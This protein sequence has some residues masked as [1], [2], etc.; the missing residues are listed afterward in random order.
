MKSILVKHQ[1]KGWGEK[2]YQEHGETLRIRPV[3]RYDDECGNGHNS[4]SIT[5]SI[6]R[7]NG[8]GNWVE[9]AG[10][11]CHEDIA[12]HFPE[13]AP[14]IKWHLCA[15]DGPMHYFANTM[16]LAGDK[17]CY[18][19]K[20]GEVHH[21]RNGRTGKICWVLEDQTALE[22]YVDSYTKP[23]GVRVLEYVP[24]TRI[25]EGKVPEL[26]AARRTAIWPEATLEQLQ[27]KEELEKHLAKIIPEFK[28]AVES[29]G[30]IY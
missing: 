22:K 15:S 10:G 13:L 6:D 1:K 4:F 8:R 19:L 23:E 5:A 30:F 18:G 17:D 11:C 29:L 28:E 26:E 7:K 24:L 21:I 12:K 27:S 3:V 14:Y 25:G 20:K 2:I 16:Y 9:Y